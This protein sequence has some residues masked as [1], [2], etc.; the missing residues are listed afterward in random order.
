LL[1]VLTIILRKRDKIERTPDG[2]V[3]Q[4]DIAVTGRAVRP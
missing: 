4:L 2:A 1:W 3:C